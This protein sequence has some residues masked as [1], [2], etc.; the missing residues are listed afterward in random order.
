MQTK[1]T[2]SPS[3]FFTELC[4]YEIISMKIVS[5]IQL[6]NRRKYFHGTGYKS[7]PILDDVQRIRTLTPST[8]FAELCPFKIFLM[9]MSTL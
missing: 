2:I 8:I 7:K 5:A 6:K 1:R 3:T 9:K 4:P